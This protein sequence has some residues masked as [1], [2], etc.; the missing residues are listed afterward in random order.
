M[1]WRGETEEQRKARER[2]GVR[3]FALLP[4]QMHDG[5][6]VWLE[7]Y[8]QARKRGVWTGKGGWPFVRALTREEALRLAAPPK[9][10]L[11]PKGTNP[12]LRGSGAGKPEWT[13][14]GVGGYK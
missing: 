6:W 13:G 5:T 8:W 1:R 3:R 9:G 11:P 10:P 14:S 7:N 4:T 12:K 2:E